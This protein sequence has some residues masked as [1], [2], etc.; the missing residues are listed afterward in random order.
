MASPG[1]GPAEAGFLARLPRPGREAVLAA[2][3]RRR[4]A[5]GELLVG[6]GDDATALLLV[7]EGHVV[8]RLNVESGAR[9]TLAVL[10][11]GDILGEVGLLTQDQE[12]TADVVALDRVE[13]L[14]LHRA[15]FERIRR[16]TREVD[17]FVMQLMARRIDRLSH[18][19]A[20]A[21]HLP[22][23]QRV[24]RRLHEVALLYGSGARVRVPLT[25][26]DLAD[27]AGAAR[28]TV[29]VVLRRL[30][31]QGVLRQGRGGVEV[32]VDAL[33]RCR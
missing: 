15:A 25:Q 24:A 27:L 1:A 18:R 21:H 8:V 14:V 33:R 11:P 2:G 16:S 3:V 26:E 17:D 12:R 6:D 7:V 22:V 28:P 30:E 9:V 19:V 13:A 20:E 23:A 31:S 10:G 4:W 29:N 5:P 32:D